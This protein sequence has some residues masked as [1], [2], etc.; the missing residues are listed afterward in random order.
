MNARISSTIAVAV[1]LAMT[2]AVAAADEDATGTGKIIGTVVDGSG[3]PVA[4][5]IVVAQQAG[6]KMREAI[7]ANTDAEGKLTM[8]NVPEGQ[9]NLKVNT[10]DGRL[11]GT[12]TVNVFADN[13]T[14]AGSI[15]VKPR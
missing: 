13:T 14:N 4:D 2:L 15:T 10:R 9:W 12:K 3:K 8:E 5:C 7:Q 11:R 1:M 6:K